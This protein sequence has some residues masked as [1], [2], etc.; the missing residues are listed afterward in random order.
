MIIKKEN[1]DQI[2][3]CAYFKNKEE[4]KKAINK[5]QNNRPIKVKVL[6]TTKAIIKRNMRNWA[7]YNKKKILGI[8]RAVCEIC[9]SRT[10]IVVH[11][12]KYTNNIND[13]RVLCDNCHKK[14]HGKKELP[15]Q[16][17]IEQFLNGKS[18]Y[19]LAKNYDINYKSMRNFICNKL[20]T[21]ENINNFIFKKL[22]Q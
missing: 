6:N 4:R 18:I 2:V 5:I 8:K 21:E 11:H 22:N 9:K 17:V 10:N 13:L 1:E 14:L 7:K 19:E 15:N 16:E 20:E 12:D 3:S